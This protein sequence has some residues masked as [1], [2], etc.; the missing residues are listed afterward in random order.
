MD[1]QQAI[2][3]LMELTAI[4]IADATQLVEDHGADGLEEAVSKARDGKMISPEAAS[5]ARMAL[6]TNLNRDRCEQ[7]IDRNRDRVTEDIDLYAAIVYVE[8]RGEI[9]PRV[10]RPALLAVLMSVNSD[11]AQK[12]LQETVTEFSNGLPSIQKAI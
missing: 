7:A 9:S 6:L 10:A 8:R 5:V 3:R 1:S 11:V 12:Y 4:T 2:A